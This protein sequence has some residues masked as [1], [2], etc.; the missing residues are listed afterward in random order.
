MLAFFQISMEI[1]W[2]WL[3][4]EEISLQICILRILED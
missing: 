3:Q 4:T 2:E 1:N